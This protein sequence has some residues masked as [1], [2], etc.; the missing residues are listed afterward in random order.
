MEAHQ[1]SF[2]DIALRLCAV[3]L[4]VLLNGFFVAAEF[5]IV[6]V[7]STQIEALVKRRHR[8]ATVADHVI[9]H[10]DAYLSATQLGITL[11]SL[12]L[13]WMGEPF[14]AALL[15]SFL[16]GFGLQARTVVSSV[17][18]GVAFAIITFLHIVIGELAPKSLAI[19]RAQSTALWVAIPLTFFYKLFYPA[20]WFLNRVANRILRLIGIEPASESDLSHSEEELRL[21]LAN[22][23][24]SEGESSLSRRILMNA[25]SLKSLKARNIMLPHNK[26]VVLF[27][28]Q[29]MEASLRIAQA[30]RHTRFPLCRGSI[31]HVIGMVHIKDLLCIRTGG[32]GANVESV[33]RE[34]LFVP[35]FLRL[36][37]LLSMFLEKR[38]HMAM[39]VDEF[40]VTLGMVTLEDVLEELVGEIQDEFDQ[41]QPLILQIRDQEYLVDGSTPLHDVEE[42]F[43][44]RFNEQ[45]DA[46]TLGG[47]VVNRWQEIPPEGT[48][49]TFENLRFI[50]Q[51]VEKFRVSQVRVV[52]DSK[53]SESAAP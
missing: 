47:Y 49:W 39:V 51:R 37:A 42:A 11:A 4:L 32:A 8:R 26:I 2:I 22:P 36:D 24:N 45:S 33:K 23:G 40:G 46:A 19:Q 10:M 30:S 50:V 9:Q 7:R 13:G 41:E 48:E 14:I 25:F 3:M 17:S 15:E 52:V 5:A 1:Y 20:I 44:V 34:I 53:P 28:D 27:A 29:P 31:D 6:K 38:C 12:G 35:E 21:L 43:G 18:F 16:F